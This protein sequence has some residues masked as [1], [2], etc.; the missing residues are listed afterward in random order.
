M[1][2]N[3]KRVCLF[4]VI[5][6]VLVTSI[7]VFAAA[8]VLNAAEIAKQVAVTEAASMLEENR[9]PGV[10]L[11]FMEDNT[12]PEET[13][14]LFEKL[15]IL[16]DLDDRDVCRCCSYDDNFGDKLWYELAVPED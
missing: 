6:A 5:V 13:Q 8:E 16:N 9:E 7:P 4:A 2:F 14:K 1:F 15:G 3:E 12:S 10:L 11:V